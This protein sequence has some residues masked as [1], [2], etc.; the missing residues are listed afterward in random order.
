M[1][2]SV[3][4]FAATKS[5][6]L[7][8]NNDRGDIEMID[9]SDGEEDFGPDESLAPP[10][11]LKVE[12]EE[13][14]VDDIAMM[15]AMGLPTEFSLAGP[16]PG[17][18]GAGGGLGPAG[19]RKG[20]KQTYY[21]EVCYVELN[22]AETKASHE[23]GV[24]HIKRM[25]IEKERRA[26]QESK[27]GV[28]TFFPKASTLPFP[29]NVVNPESDSA[30]L[31]QAIK[32]IE[33][34]LPVQKKIPIR[35]CEKLR[36]TND[37]IVGLKYI[38][39]I[40]ACSSAEVEPF[41]Q[42]HLCGTQG[43]ANG[44]FNHLKGKAHRIGYLRKKFKQPAYEP[45]KD[46]MMR[47]V[48]KYRENAEL[49]GIIT[50]YSDEL[51]PW[52]GGKAPWSVER[53]GTGFKPTATLQAEGMRRML[54]EKGVIDEPASAA[55]RSP[56]SRVK[57]QRPTAPLDVRSLNPKDLRPIRSVDEMT[58]ALEVVRTTVK[59]IVEFQKGRCSQE[60]AADISVHLASISNNI[61]TLASVCASASSSKSIKRERSR[62][63]TPKSSYRGASTSRYANDRARPNRSPSYS[64]NHSRD[65]SRSPSGR[66]NRY[67][68]RSPTARSSSYYH[69]RSR[70]KRENIY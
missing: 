18:T 42:C 69:E 66:N 7:S 49:S 24:K 19:V 58:H 34:P 70:I 21:C 55:R 1:S 13:E 44:M 17:W 29:V 47:E 40:I 50:I 64:S 4:S 61:G 62:S 9:V 16:G 32:Q 31:L 57:R 60:D 15:A 56:S 65:R 10:P 46:V 38:S 51:Y 54:I 8:S 37:P 45:R 35:L 30:L 48:E 33:N 59:K 25:Q 22:S 39:E 68:S 3:K 36:E 14:E 26:E 6:P 52:S 41:Y 5:E 2:L 11:P 67:R 53:G 23:K 63:P 27:T 12:K 28:K 43:E 20:E